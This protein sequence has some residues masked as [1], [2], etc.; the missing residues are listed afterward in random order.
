VLDNDYLHQ[1]FPA[2]SPADNFRVTAAHEYFH[3]VQ[4]AYDISEDPW[5]MEA[6][7]TW[8]EDE[9]YDSINDNLQYLRYG[10]MRHPEQS[11]DQFS[12]LF[13]YGTWSFFRFLTE[14]FGASQGGMPTLVRD[15]WRRLDDAPGGPDDYSL[16]GLIKVLRTHKLSLPDAFAAFSAANRMPARSYDEGKANHYPAAPLAGQTTLSPEHLS[17]GPRAITLDHLTAGTVRYTPGKKLSAAGWKLRLSLNMAP[18]WQGTD[19]IV[20]VVPRHGA[21]RRS[22][23]KLHKNGDVTRAIG[24]SSRSVKF[25][26]VTLVNA[27][28]D[29]TC[30]RNTPFSC[31]GRPKFD[32]QVQRISARAIRS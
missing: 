29:F 4:F 18:R 9:L 27:S 15:L 7:A 11:M 14:R 17:D 3:A 1:Q 21:P 10:P 16:Q 13:H 19:A 20:T 8:A 22:L 28:D 5:I 26:E 6:T 2:N 12:G 31:A 23:V 30:N 24:F 25:V 32:N